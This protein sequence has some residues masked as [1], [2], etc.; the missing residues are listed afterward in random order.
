M[1]VRGHKRGE[2]LEEPSE[3][4]SRREL[5]MNAEYDT[6][7]AYVLRAKVLTYPSFG[8]IKESALT[9]EDS[10]LRGESRRYFSFRSEQVA[11]KY[12]V[13]VHLGAMEA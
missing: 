2:G 4:F 1:E 7:H 13:Q 10:R 11:V 12:E 3:A 6:G 5:V 9:S 8:D